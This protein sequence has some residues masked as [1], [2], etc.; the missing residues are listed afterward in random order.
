MRSID[1]KHSSGPVRRAFSPFSGQVLMTAFSINRTPSKE[2]RECIAAAIG[3]TERRVQVWFQNRRQRAAAGALSTAQP[4]PVAMG[5]PAAPTSAMPVLAVPAVRACA[6]QEAVIRAPQPAAVSASPVA[7]PTVPL[8][9][10][11]RPAA[12][13]PSAGSGCTEGQTVDGMKMEVRRRTR[14]RA[15]TFSPCISLSR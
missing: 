7:P 9:P 12:R 10:E 13:A 1:H 4:A 5:I 8:A 14:D 6:P 3:T 15:L 2:Q 11:Q